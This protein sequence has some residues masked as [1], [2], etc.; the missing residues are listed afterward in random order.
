VVPASAVR[1]LMEERPS[2]EEALRRGSP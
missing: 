2:L 1:R